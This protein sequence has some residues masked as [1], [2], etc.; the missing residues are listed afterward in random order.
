MSNSN[1][2]QPNVNT[3]VKLDDLK[4]TRQKII[5]EPFL[6]MYI[7]VVCIAKLVSTHYFF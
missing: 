1:T 4:T 5:I 3:F 6:Q 7:V 2:F